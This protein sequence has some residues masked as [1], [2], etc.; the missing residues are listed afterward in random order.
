VGDEVRL[1]AAEAA[2]WGARLGRALAAIR[3]NQHFPEAAALAGWMAAMARGPVRLAADA[4]LPAAGEWARARAGRELAPAALAELAGVDA[5]RLPTEEAGRLAA[6]RE[7]LAA[8]AA[9]PPLPSRRVEVQLRHRERGRA[10]W[11]VRVDRVDLV[12]G[13]LA[14]YTL[15][16]GGRADGRISDGE[17]DLAATERFSQQLDVL[18]AQ[19]AALAFAVL[20][21]QEGLEVDE[22][23][24]GV[25]GPAIL[26]GRAGPPL[27]W[28]VVSDGP[29]LS[30]CLERA[31]PDV[32]G[33]RVDDCLAG[34][35]VVPGE[36]ARFGVSR[37][38][39]WAAPAGEVAALTAWL[40]ARGSRGMVYGYAG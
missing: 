9:L 26:P 23:V 15:I 18:A 33:G 36:A 22:V 13:T 11:Q 29:V 6:R 17:L 8:L 7:E 1:E 37:Q 31:S 30:A 2:R 3:L 28:P 25:I 12:T 19:D 21:D 39:K 5:L 14:R 10:S 40:R 34:A 24:R 27:L 35:V 20:R 32:A 16:V 38:R 4:G